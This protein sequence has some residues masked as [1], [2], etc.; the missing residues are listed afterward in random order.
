MA[1]AWRRAAAACC[2]S[3]PWPA[4]QAES[5]TRRPWR[6]PAPA[7]CFRSPRST[8]LTEDT[9]DYGSRTLIEALAGGLVKMPLV[10]QISGGPVQLE[11]DGQGSQLVISGLTKFQGQ[12]GQAYT[13]S[14]QITNG[15]SLIDPDLASLNGVNLVGDSTGTFTISASLGLAITGGTSTVQVG[16]LVDRGE[17]G[18]SE[19]RHAQSSRAAC[20]S[21]APA[22]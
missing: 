15:G 1:R 17:S 4:T 18:R 19:Y 5:I 7:A 16:T 8:T 12:A 9:A 13:S 22:S 10:T 2:F 21:T 3:P 20:R 14:L 11:S 6:P